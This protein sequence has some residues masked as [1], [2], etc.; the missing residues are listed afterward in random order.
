MEKNYN[1]ASVF[2]DML[3]HFQKQQQLAGPG[4]DVSQDL[5]YPSH[6]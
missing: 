6:T 4:N 5:D 2:S 1:H 3:W